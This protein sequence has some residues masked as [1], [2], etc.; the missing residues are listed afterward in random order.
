MSPAKPKPAWSPADIVKPKRTIAVVE[1]ELAAVT[2]ERDHLRV[3]LGQA[4]AARV[5][6]VA[7]RDEAMA[8]RPAP[9]KNLRLVLS[10]STLRWLGEIAAA[11]QVAPAKAAE[12]LLDDLAADDRAAHARAA[13]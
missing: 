2:A 13:E 11:R 7:E 4:E 9:G 5:K 1:L 12:A 10:P 8:A 3:V 6:A